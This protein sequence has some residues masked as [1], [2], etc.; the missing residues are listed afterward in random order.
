V[1]TSINTSLQTQAITLQLLSVQKA[2]PNLPVPFIEPGRT[3]IRR[4]SLFQ[5]AD[6]VERI[7][8]FFLFSDCLLWLSKGGEREGAATTE[9]E[10]FRQSI[11]A[12]PSEHS[13]SA[14]AR[15]QSESE[16]VIR[17]A[18][19]S[20]TTLKSLG[21]ANQG[22]DEKWWFRGKI[23]L[24]N[25]DVVI[26]PTSFEEPPGLDIH[27]PQMSFSLFCGEYAL[28]HI[29]PILILLPRLD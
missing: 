16:P 6:R 4:G 1:N 9:E 13:F 27:S 18:A 19:S 21:M 26:P 17:R 10:N 29:I 14:A 24:L 11:V 22:T 23:D 2:T 8:E 5:T 3:F 28:L 15:R 25:L 7:R 20:A 12:S